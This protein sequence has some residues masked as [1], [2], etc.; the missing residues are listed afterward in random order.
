M[1]IATFQAKREDRASLPL[2]ILISEGFVFAVGESRVRHPRNFGVGLEKLC[3]GFSVAA[4]LLHTHGQCLH[5]AY[6]E[7]SIEGGHRG[8]QIAQAHCMSV[9][10]QREVPKRLLK[11]EAVVGRLREGQRRKLVVLGPVELATV[12]HR[13]PHRVPVPREELSGGMHDDIS[14]VF[15]GTAQVRRRHRVVDYQRHPLFMTEVGN[16]AHVSDDAARV[17][18]ALSP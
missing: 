2:Q 13:P 17:C 11:S 1:R 3:N 5:P 18:E 8:P 14:A 9:D 15:E 6:G 10:R 7:E 4:V 16:R 12:H